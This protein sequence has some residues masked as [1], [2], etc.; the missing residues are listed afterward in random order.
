MCALFDAC[1]ED[2]SP[3]GVRDA[4]LLSVLYGA[5]V[6]RP[7]ALRLPLEAYDRER[8]ILCWP[9]PGDEEGLRA[10]RATDGARDALE[11]WL[12][13]RGAV[14]GPLLCRLDGRTDSP[15]PLREADVS[16]ALERWRSRAAVDEL[17]EADLDRLYTSPWWTNA[18]G[19]ETQ[20]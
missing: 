3:R 17:D 13:L 10:R 9:A 12:E 19:R 4:A 5:G 14:A 18:A 15:R 16:A 6:P 20:G 11:D 1:R 8:A 2:G 7:V